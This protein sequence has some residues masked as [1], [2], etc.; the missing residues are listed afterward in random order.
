MKPM[1]SKL[2]SLTADNVTPMDIGIS[3]NIVFLSGNLF[4]SS[5]VIPTLK[6]GANAWYQQ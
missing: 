2:S 3:E 5:H 1:N 4:I 6:I